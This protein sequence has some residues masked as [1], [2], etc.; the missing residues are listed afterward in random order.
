MDAINKTPKEIVGLLDQ[1]VIGQDEAKKAIAIALRNRYR[2]MQLDAAMQEEISPKNMLMIGPT[3]VGKTEIAR[4][5][6]KIV[7]AP[8]TKVEASKFTEVGY[9]GRDVES[10][11]RDLVEVSVAMEKQDQFKNVRADA[12]Q[13][14]NKRLVKLLAPAKKK[15]NKNNNDFSNMMNMFSQMQNGQMPTAPSEQEE[16][17]DEIRNERLSLTEQLNKG[18]LENHMVELEMDD[19]QQASAT[20]NNMLGQMGID[21]NDT[22]G[23]IMPKKRI[24]RTVTV[25]EAREILVSEE[26]EK[27]VNNADINH[28]AI[29][30]AE[31]TGIIFLDEIDK[32]TKG[33]GQNSGDVSREGVQRDILPIVEGTQVKTKYGTIDT[34]HI[35]FIAAGAFAESK[36]SDLIAE[37]QGRFPIRVELNDLSKKDFVRILTEPNNALIKQYI[38]LIGTDNVKVTFTME[39]IERIAELAF[40]LNHENQNIGARRLQTVLEKL[41][42][43]LLY[44][45]PDMGT[46]D[47]TITESYVN[48]KIGD[49]VQNKD[50]SRYIL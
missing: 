37:L 43:D 24:K 40:E 34:D 38:A 10:M 35:L 47:V 44:E 29:K 41:L 50:L 17:T 5:L 15:E 48:D 30:R 20:D 16:V 25:A 13:A 31:N 26:S 8:F 12:T 1:Y 9:V 23:S 36:P 18:L 28:D 49:I 22:L 27:L 4:R 32:I 11:V 7:H 2:R 46:G 3:G 33:S 14:A 45:G 19:P 39:A 42:E 6:A 21:L